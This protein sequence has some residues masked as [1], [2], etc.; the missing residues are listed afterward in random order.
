MDVESPP[1]SPTLS[2]TRF[3]D[4]PSHHI[5]RQI[6]QRSDLRKSSSS[7]ASGTPPGSPPVAS[8]LTG[9]PMMRN[10][11]QRLSRMSE[12]IVQLWA[13]DCG[14]DENMNLIACTKTMQCGCMCNDGYSEDDEN[15]DNII[16]TNNAKTAMLLNKINKLNTEETNFVPIPRCCANEYLSLL[17][18]KLPRTKVAYAHFGETV[19]CNDRSCSLP[20]VFCLSIRNSASQF[21]MT[22]RV[23]AKND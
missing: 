11:Q 12:D 5:S 13:I 16:N 2:R 4:C 22:P 8:P 1:I 10:S 6:H 20:H 18:T 19:K 9:S 17:L 3:V 15:N 7:S 14:I 21:A 23:A